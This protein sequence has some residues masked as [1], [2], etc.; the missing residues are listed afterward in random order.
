GNRA[1]AAR[2]LGVHRQLLYAK[3]K[4]YG[5]DASAERTDS[6]GKADG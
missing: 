5:L 2:E 6:V 1:A 3:I 4:R